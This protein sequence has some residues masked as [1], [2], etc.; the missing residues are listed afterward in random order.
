MPE[1]FWLSTQPGNH[2]ARE[3]YELRGMVLDRIEGDPGNERAIYV[4]RPRR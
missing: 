1:G 4:M 2:R 3:F